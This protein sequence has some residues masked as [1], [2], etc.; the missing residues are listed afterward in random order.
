MIMPSKYIQEK[1]ALIGVSA[2]I[3]PYVDNG[4]MLSGLWEVLKKESIITNFERFI[5]ALDLLFI[6]GV[7]NIEDNIIKRAAND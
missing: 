1:D 5:L 3:T 6:L 7:V 4:L 2:L